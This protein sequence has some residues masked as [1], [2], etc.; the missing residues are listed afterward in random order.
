MTAFYSTF[1]Y[2]RQ[3]IYLDENGILRRDIRVG[4]EFSPNSKRILVAGCG[5]TEAG[6]IAQQLPNAQI[7]GVDSSLPS[8][9]KCQVMLDKSKIKNVELI[10]TDLRIHESKD[11]YDTLVASGVLHHIE[12][13]ED[14]LKHLTKSLNDG[15][16]FYGMVYSTINRRHIL[17]TI[18]NFES[19]P[20]NVKGVGMVREFFKQ[21][22]PKNAS[23]IW[24]N[25][26][27]QSDE[28]V[29]DTW[30]NPYFKHY[31]MESLH[32]LLVNCNFADMQILYHRNKLSFSAEFSSYAYR[33]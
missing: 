25:M 23:S 3:D 13:V 30:L 33:L 21:L 22:D 32:S 26:H 2:P 4:Y 29:A 10:H 20:K 8:L 15:A 18:K 6:I 17:E 5:T 7:V 1:N 19:F 9:E 16:I 14:T 31:D 27:D 11:K 12:N 24:W 28:E